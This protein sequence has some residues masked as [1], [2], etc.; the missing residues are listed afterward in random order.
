MLSSEPNIQPFMHLSDVA[1]CMRQTCGGRSDVLG[2]VACFQ[3][4]ETA[5]ER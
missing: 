1:E 2:K 3:W 4:K 5:T